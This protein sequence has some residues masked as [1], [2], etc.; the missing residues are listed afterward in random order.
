MKFTGGN[1]AVARAWVCEG[2]SL[3]FIARELG[4]SRATVRYNLRRGPIADRRRK[5]SSKLKY[6]VASRRRLV[7]KLALL[8]Q[9]V[10]STTN[11]SRRKS[12][13]KRVRTFSSLRK[14]TYALRTQ[15]K[16]KYSFST[17]RRD[18]IA[19]G[20]VAKKK[21]KGP[22]R[23]EGDE[24]RRVDFARKFLKV[25][26]RRIRFSD[27]KLIDCN[28]TSPQWQW[29]TAR[30]TPERREYEKFSPKLH[31]WGCI[32]WNYKHLVFL[33]KGGVTAE[34][35]VHRCLESCKREL[36][37]Q[38]V[39]LLHDNARPHVAQVTQAWLQNNGVNIV[40]EF[41]PRSPD[42][43]VI[44]M[45][46]SRLGR[47]VASNRPTTERNLRKYVVD[48]WNEIAQSEINKLCMTFPKRLSQCIAQ[49]GRTV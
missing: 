17:I 2:R 12:S 27:E 33:E 11:W 24:E 31:V 15:Y 14:I 23:Y 36:Q 9:T 8:S 46:W 28:E 43:N 47:L 7:R 48:S 40:E 45:L 6:G 39:L 25:D 49:R 34:T 35:Y 21:P 16:M 37:K 30:E 26:A 20:L 13:I 29:C 38:N 19:S 44:E 10:R 22:K 3:S 42:L 1:F 5:K 18:M 32:G 4:C 41:P